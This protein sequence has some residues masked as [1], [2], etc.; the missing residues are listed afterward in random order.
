MCSKCNTI[1]GVTCEEGSLNVCSEAN[2]YIDHEVVENPY[3]DTNTNTNTSN[4]SIGRPCSF[5]NDTDVITST[6]NDYHAM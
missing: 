1:G 2:R 6:K 3:Y 4:T 5:M